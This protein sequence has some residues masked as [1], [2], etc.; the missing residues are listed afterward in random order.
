MKKN[1]LSVAL[2]VVSGYFTASV[3]ADVT[4]QFTRFGFENVKTVRENN[5]TH[6]TYESNLY[7]WNVKE[8]AAAM[9]LAVEEELSDTIT[10]V[11]LR[12]E[13]PV[14]LTTF[15][16]SDWQAFRKGEMNAAQ[17]QERI[18]IRR[19]FSKDEM[20]RFKATKAANSS[21]GKF[22]LVIYPDFSFRNVRINKVYDVALSL[23]PAFEFSLWKGNKFTAQ[24]VLPLINE[25]Y[26]RI[27]S[28]VRPGFL[29]ISQDFALPS[30]W[31]IRLAAGNFNTFRA[32]VDADVSHFFGKERW[33]LGLNTGITGSS[34]F[35]GFSKWYYSTPND[36]TLIG[37]IGYYFNPLE[38]EVVLRA[39]HFYMGDW[40]TRLDIFRHMHA[41]EVGIYAQVG[42]SDYNAG[43]HFTLPLNIPS[44]YKRKGFRVR[45][46]RYYDLEYVYASGINK[47][48]Y[49]ETRPNEN[50]SEH[51]FNPVYI[52]KELLKLNKK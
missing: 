10:L 16:R 31:Y 9:D 33:E 21:R 52:K 13:N 20:K 25:D 3:K 12:D 23:S 50:R 47:L 39:G 40:G 43:F 36:W 30:S 2:L 42:E 49:Y 11:T 27:Y 15:C 51:F 34:V 28:K 19:S 37:R 46:P 6:I 5:H 14:L 22:D 8:L 4:P 32:G 35:D 41:V 48:D 18:N 44:K 26:G 29:T 17:V 38:T 24:L 7:V 1:I 45:A